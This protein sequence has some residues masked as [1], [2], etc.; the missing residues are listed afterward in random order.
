MEFLL[1]NWFTT[2]DDFSPFSFALTIYIMIIISNSHRFTKIEVDPQ[3]KTPDGKYYDVLFI[4]TGIVD[5]SLRLMT[6]IRMKFISS[7]R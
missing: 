7:N 5:Y 3:V 2:D 6:I 4:G 1:F